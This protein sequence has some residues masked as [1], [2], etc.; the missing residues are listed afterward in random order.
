M[1]TSYWKTHFF[2][3]QSTHRE[4]MAAS[5]VHSLVMEKLANAGEGEGGG[6][7]PLSL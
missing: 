4:A 2:Q 1:S 7:H 3:P 5:D 6:A